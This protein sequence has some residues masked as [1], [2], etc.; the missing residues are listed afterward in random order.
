MYE[1]YEQSP[2]ALCQSFSLSC[3]AI[4]AKKHCHRQ[5]SRAHVVERWVRFRPFGG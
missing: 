4:L 2:Q 5:Q 3:V 1:I